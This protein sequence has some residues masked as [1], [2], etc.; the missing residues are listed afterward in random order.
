MSIRLRLTLTY[1]IILALTLILFSTILY[2]TQSHTTYDN[3]KQDLVRQASASTGGG[4]A[5]NPQQV[6]PGGGSFRPSLP[7][8]AILPSGTLPGRYTQTRSIDGTITGQT[9]DLSG[10]SLPLSDNGLAAVHNGSDWFETAQV[11]E[12]PLL[13]YS[14]PTANQSGVIQILQVAFPI[15]QAERSLTMLRLILVIGCSLA[16]VAAFVIGWLLAGMALRPIHRITSTAQAIGAERNFSRRVEHHGSNDEVGQLA[17]TFNEMLSELESAYRQIES[18]L[19]SQ[20]R[21]VADASHELRTPLTTVRGNMDLLRRK[22]PMAANERAEVLSDTTDEVDRL[23]RLVN[24]L[25]VLARADAGQTLKHEPVSLKLLLEDVCRQGKLIGPRPVALS[26]DI[27]DVSVLADHDALKQ[28]LL[29][30][31]DNAHVH[32]PPDAQI[33]LSATSTD[34]AVSISVSDN[35]PGIAPDVLN[36]VFERFYRGAVS[37]SGPGAGLGLAIAKELV[38]AQDGT[39]VVESEL[40]KGSTFTVMLPQPAD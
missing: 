5:P 9:L 34:G 39:I 25:L 40:G 15:A 19:D 24:Q 21:F 18:A 3:I 27:P 36:H 2:V 33:T 8:D 28:V 14:R 35:G 37:R 22:P 6:P 11:Q 32:T 12:Q 10:S 4:R 29:I 16:I 38:E 26:E 7:L 13:I 1:S 17:V 31:V 30:L 20:R 23:I